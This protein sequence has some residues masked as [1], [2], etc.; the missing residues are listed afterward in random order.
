MHPPPVATTVAAGPPRPVPGLRPLPLVGAR[1]DLLRFFADPITHLLALA[2]VGPVASM[3]AGSADLVFAFGARHNHTVLSDPATWPN[4]V[5]PPFPLPPG[6]A[7]TRIFAG[8]MSMNGEEHRRHRR[9]LLP[10]V[11][12]AAVATYAEDIV[13]VSDRHLAQWG[14][15][16]PFDVVR[17]STELTTAV[18]LRCLFGA[19]LGHGEGAELARTSADLLKLF[20]SPLTVL[21][22]WRLPGLPYARF[23]ATCEA[24]EARMRQMIAARG[25]EGDGRRDVLS[26]LLR[27]RDE[28]AGG[29]TDEQVIAHMVSLVFAGQDA[30]VTTLSLTLLLLTQH[31]AVL[32]DLGEELDATLG[33]A[34]PTPATL[35]RLPLLDRVVNESM[36]LL[37]AIVH[38]LPRRPVADARLGDHLVPAGSTVLLSPLVTH[39]D[40]EVFPDPMRF[41]PGRWGTL[42]PS[43]YAWLPFGAGPR[44]CLGAGF[45]SHILRVQ[46]AMIL[47]HHR[48]V[49]LPGTRVDLAVRAANLTLR[50]PLPL[51]LLP[52]ADALTTV[53]PVSGNVRRLVRLP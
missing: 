20:T 19:E 7:A 46:L 21:A 18:L 41:D 33:G 30:I 51:R 1:A 52:R 13:E 36:R 28:E 5:Q 53:E 37:P 25:R 11:S 49:L 38:L 40:P 12:K 17:A 22:P 27:A 4:F 26:I 15:G 34:P 48:P 29:L 6:S 39:R 44:T 3:T 14:N 9:L 24:A 16:E 35:G 43:P 42:T 32:A 45:A 50:S 2:D 31:P 8:T 23:L 47:Q 10:V